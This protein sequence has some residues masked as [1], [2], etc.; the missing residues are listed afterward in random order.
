MR[1]NYLYLMANMTFL[2]EIQ[3]YL[4][5][6]RNILYSD[7]L[8]ISREWFADLNNSNKEGRTDRQ[9]DSRT[10]KSDI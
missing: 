2:G 3:S 4:W 10:Q 5:Q 1:K 6:N 9:T 7:Y 8:P